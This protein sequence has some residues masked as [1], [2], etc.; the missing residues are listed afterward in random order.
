MAS[1]R[2]AGHEPLV[3]SGRVAAK[4]M[5]LFAVAEDSAMKIAS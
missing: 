1:S 2:R 4:A 5:V 3:R